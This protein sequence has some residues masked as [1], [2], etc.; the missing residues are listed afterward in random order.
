M[1]TISWFTPSDSG[2]EANSQLRCHPDRSDDIEP[3]PEVNYRTP[4]T[5]VNV[6][7]SIIGN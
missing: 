2:S 5:C 1:P 7:I 6:I 3:P 4:R